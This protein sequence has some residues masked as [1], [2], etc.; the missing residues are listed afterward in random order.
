M[1]IEQTVD[2]LNA[3]KLGA[4]ADAVQQQLQSGEAATLGFEERFGLL[5][6]AEWTA[7]TAAVFRSVDPTPAPTAGTAY[8]GSTPSRGRTRR[9]GH[10][11]LVDRSYELLYIYAQGQCQAAVRWPVGTRCASTRSDTTR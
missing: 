10:S 5:V 6:D 2:K 3:M 11:W 4:M 7:P 8:A 9:A 1:L